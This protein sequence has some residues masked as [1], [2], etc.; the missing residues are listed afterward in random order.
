MARMSA[1]GVV[2]RPR[3]GALDHPT[4][5]EVSPLLWQ[6]ALAVR[7]VM[8]RTGR[9]P[10]RPVWL[11]SYE[12]CLR[13]VAAL[14]RRQCDASVYVTGT[15]AQDEPVFGVSDVDM[16]VV[17][18]ATEQ[19]PERARIRLREHW[20]GLCQRAPA[21]SL[22]VAE[23]FAYHEEEL[24]AAAS[25]SCLT[26][27]LEDHAP[28]AVTSFFGAHRLTDEAG[29]Q[30][31]PGVWPTRAWRLVAGKD[32]RPALV[33]DP[34]SSRLLAWLELQ[35]WWR[36]AFDLSVGPET[37]EL[38]PFQMP[39]LCVKLVAEPIRILLSFACGERVLKRKVALERGL[40][41]FPDEEPAIRCALDLLAN[42]HRSPSADLADFLPSLVRLSSRLV[43]AIADDLDGRGVTQVALLGGDDPAIPLVAP[44]PVHEPAGSE[45][46][47]RL[48]PLT[49]WLARVRPRP[50]EEAFV[51]LDGD[52]SDRRQLAATVRNYRPGVYRALRAGGLMVFPATAPRRLLRSVQCGQSDP[53]S[54]ALADGLSS[55]RFPNVP[56]WSA[57]DCARRAV[58]EHRGWLDSQPAGLAGADP[59]QAA[60]ALGMLLSAARAAS[61]LDSV[62]DGDPQLAVTF[63]AATE[64]LASSDSGASTVAAEGY[65]EYK[66]AT[67]ESR[68]PSNRTL[69]GLFELVSSL[70][71]YRAARLRC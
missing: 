36:F 71:A 19:P 15:F 9:G 30:V 35:F 59:G 52:P 8:Q 24:H 50:Q 18:P 48:R 6:L 21:L 69:T 5:R 42:L 56:G 28:G 26:C 45:R 46:L 41:L 7:R 67:L 1:P 40:E 13:G 62:E 66:A 23:V 43:Q 63:A 68:A 34:E 33:D 54:F 64:L 2:A 60:D 22:V 70:P 38:H 58:A 14:L 12:L 32:V 65:G 51:V 39:F 47:P 3:P 25:S 31:R 55:A 49:D 57:R 53:V 27:G 16:V 17:A 4:R 10:L 44:A 61:F 29:L 11:L 20:L 37:H